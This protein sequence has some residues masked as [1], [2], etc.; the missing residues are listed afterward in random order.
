MFYKLC[1]GYYKDIDWYI[2]YNLSDMKGVT[3]L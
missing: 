3:S 2:W 1:N